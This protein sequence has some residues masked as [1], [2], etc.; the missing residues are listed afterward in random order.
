MAIDEILDDT[1]QT[2]ARERPDLDFGGAELFLKLSSVVRISAVAV[3]DELARL[4]VS[5]PEFDV[6]ATLRRHGP[7]ARL[8][9]GH[10]AHVAMVKPSGLSHRLSRLEGLGL[11]MREL[12][13]ADRRSILVQITPA[14]RE[15]AD[16]GIEITTRHQ[17]EVFAGLSDAQ[18][19]SLLEAVD[20]L[21]GR[22]A[23]E[24][25]TLR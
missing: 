15:I 5:I 16:R 2:W 3:R 1:L 21:V 6:L 23:A 19:K 20:L 8:T 24:P 17:H 12:D 13:P 22:L 14:G 9:P 4:G 7:G 10:I 25:I 18:Q 11:V